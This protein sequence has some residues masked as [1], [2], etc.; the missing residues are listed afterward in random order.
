MDYERCESIVT[1]YALRL[2]AVDSPS[3]F[4]E[5]VIALVENFAAE[6]GYASRR[7]RRG[8][9]IVSVPG[10]DKSRTVALASH[11]DTLGLMVRA[12]KENGELLITPIGGPLLPTLDGEYCRVYARDG[13]VYTGTILSMSP[14]AH[15]FKDAKTRPRDDENMYVRI[16]AVVKTREDVLALGVGVGDYVC[17]DP[18]F[19]VTETGFLKSRFIDDK[20]S[21]AC[22]LTMLKLMRDASVRP[23]CN[24][25]FIFT[26]Y[27]EVGSGGATVPD[28]LDELLIVDMGCIGQDL[29]CNERQ[30]SV[31]A[32]DSAGPYDYAMTSRLVELA[33]VHGIDCAVDVYPMYSSDA[34]VAWHAGHDVPAALIGPGVHASHGM[35]RTHLTAL[36]GTVRLIGL[37]LGCE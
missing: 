17:I 10:R 14:A 9:L 16:D 12:V 20:G 32:K 33:R 23:R 25:E 35:E 3:G 4:T 30:V 8:N 24:T 34:A 21:A 11:V 1:D 27:E 13:R 7:T 37:Y 31:C 36:V 19:T 26:V 18:K 15:V 29:S 5:R 2:L 28:D 6:L 22:L